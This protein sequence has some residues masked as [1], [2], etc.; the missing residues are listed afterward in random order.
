ML[1][2]A[3][4]SSGDYFGASLDGLVNKR[5]V[6]IVDL[7]GFGHWIDDQRAEFGVDAHVEAL[8]QALKALGLASSSVV[9]VAHSTSAAIALSWADRHRSRMRHVFLW[10]PPICRAGTTAPAIGTKFAPLAQLLIRTSRCAERTH[11]MI[12]TSEHRFLGAALMTVIVPRWPTVLRREAGTATWGA[13]QEALRSLVLDF[14]W[15]SVLP[16][17]VPLTVFYGTEDPIGD[18]AFIVQISGG[19]KLVRV[20]YTDDH[21]MVLHPEFIFDELDRL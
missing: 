21:A 4:G 8:E 3:L 1:L 17:S 14:N 6:V 7:L 18:E 20:P 15:S 10:G 5:R 2:H 19:A 11:R 12:A 9:V 16:A 13:F